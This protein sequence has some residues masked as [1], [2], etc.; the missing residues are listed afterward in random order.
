MTTQILSNGIV[1]KI[2][3]C[4]HCGVATPLLSLVGKPKLHYKKEYDQFWYFAAQCSRC[5]HQTLFYG[6]NGTHCDESDDIY[7]QEHYPPLRKAND[8]LPTRALKFLQ[9]AMESKHAPDGALMLSAS[10]I[11][12]MM[13][14]IGYKDGSLY[15][16]IEQASTDGVLTRQMQEWAHEIRLSANEPRHADDQFE[17]ATPEEAEQAL[18]FASALGEYLFVLPARVSKWKQKVPPKPNS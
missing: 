4:P 13:K 11:D 2:R 6:A 9:Q 12:A 3:Q 1:Y 17:G 15:A 10:A 7:I 5:G 18:E 16:R 8:E 14:E